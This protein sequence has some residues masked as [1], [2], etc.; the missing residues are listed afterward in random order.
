MDQTLKTLLFDTVKPNHLKEVECLMGYIKAGSPCGE[1]LFLS[2]GETWEHT[3]DTL[4]GFLGETPKYT[5]GYQ[6][7]MYGLPALR[8]V[9]GKYVAKDYGLAVPIRQGKEFEIAVTWTG[10]RNAMY[11]YGRLLRDQYFGTQPPQIITTAPGW[12]YPGVFEPLGYK[13]QYINLPKEKNFTP[14]IEAF[15]EVILGS[16]GQKAL[17]VINAQHNPTSINWSEALVRG[18]IRL[19][20]EH[21]LAI[22]ID[23]AHYGV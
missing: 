10:T 4:T 7:S 17:L 3:P 5:H 9:L 1:P 8:T 21:S 20:L 19:A 22:L 12:D 11:D 6:L 23:D 16:K 13:T 2:L 15:K 14:N 18:I